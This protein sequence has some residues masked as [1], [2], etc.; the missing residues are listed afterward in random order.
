MLAFK[1]QT[2]TTRTLLRSSAPRLVQGSLLSIRTH[3]HG[4]KTMK[5]PQQKR[6]SPSIQ[7]NKAGPS[8]RDS[9]KRPRRLLRCST[10]VVFIVI[11]VIADIVLETICV[12][13]LQKLGLIVPPAQPKIVARDAVDLMGKENAEWLDWY[14]REGVGEKKEREEGFFLAAN[15]FSSTPPQR[16]DPS[17]NNMIHLLC[18]SRAAD[19][20][21]NASFETNH[22][23]SEYLGRSPEKSC[24]TSTSYLFPTFAKESKR[25][26]F[27]AALFTAAGAVGGS[28][29]HSLSGNLELLLRSGLFCLILS[30]GNFAD[31]TTI[32]TDHHDA[33]SPPHSSNVTSTNSR[34]SFRSNSIPSTIQNQTTLQTQLLN[35]NPSKRVLQGFEALKKVF[36]MR[37]QGTGVVVLAGAWA[38]WEWQC[39]AK[40]RKFMDWLDKMK[41]GASM[42]KGVADWK[43][44]KKENRVEEGAVKEGV[45]N[46]LKE[47]MDAREGRGVKLEAE[48]DEGI[49]TK[50]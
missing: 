36:K 44:R 6:P 43:W 13:I 42:A 32:L 14:A 7:Q 24:K 45:E 46:R 40:V 11:L 15:I 3:K 4:W 50:G 17:W 28:V 19:P 2:L 8:P 49:G 10:V 47:L 23:N 20:V 25:N 39:G 5:L 1:L 12:A 33:F 21:T 37:L 26:F 29:G 48:H 27:L 22:L 18:T 34:K 30:L 9:R 41:S 35:L 31:P 38:A 16:P